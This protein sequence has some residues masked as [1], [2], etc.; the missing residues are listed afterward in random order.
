MEEL[1]KRASK[2]VADDEVATVSMS[3]STQRRAVLEAVAFGSFLR[4]VE[5]HV[6]T[7]YGLL[8]PY[9]YPGQPGGPEGFL[10][11]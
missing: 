9:K 8:T 1:M 2:A 7:T 4:E 11:S 6:D 3:I 10:P 5:T